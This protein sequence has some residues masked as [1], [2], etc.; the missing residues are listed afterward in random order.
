V[1]QDVRNFYCRRYPPFRYLDSA[2]GVH[3]N[4]PKIEPDDWCGEFERKSSEKFRRIAP[5]RFPP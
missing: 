1:D 3:F 5:G 2:G 4:W